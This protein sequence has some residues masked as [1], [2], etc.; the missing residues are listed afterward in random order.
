MTG[1][2]SRKAFVR[3]LQ[4]SDFPEKNDLTPDSECAS[5]SSDPDGARARPAP[6]W[7]LGVRKTGASGM[8]LIDGFP[9]PAAMNPLLTFQISPPRRPI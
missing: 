9:T 6:K 5:L 8:T 4:F 1:K 3:T 7:F 2:P